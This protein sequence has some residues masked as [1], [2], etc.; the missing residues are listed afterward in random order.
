MNDQGHNGGEDIHTQRLEGRETQRG[1]GL[2]SDE[3][4]TAGSILHHDAHHADRDVIEFS[5]NLSDVPG[6]IAKQRNG[7][8]HKNGHE[9][10]LEHIALCQR[11]ERIGGDDP[12]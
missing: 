8:A 5:E 4:H 1:K 6:L 2:G 11:L 7:D 10:H 9:Q 12:Q 3:E